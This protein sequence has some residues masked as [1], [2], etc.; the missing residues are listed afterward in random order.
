MKI[1]VQ[2]KIN[3]VGIAEVT[4]LQDYEVR[5]N[6]EQLIINSEQLINSV[7]IFDVLGRLY[8]PLNPPSRGEYSPFEGGRG[9]SEVRFDI[10]HLAIGMYFIKI[11]TDK[12]LCWKNHTKSK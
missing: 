8:T 3:D 4:K 1:V 10:S 12:T 2:T 5:I 6:N 7:E 11:N 9:M